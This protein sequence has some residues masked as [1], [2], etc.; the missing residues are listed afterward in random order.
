MLRDLFLGVMSSV[1]V[2]QCGLRAAGIGPER[3]D[4]IPVPPRA[5][6]CRARAGQ[7]LPEVSCGTTPCSAGVMCEWQPQRDAGI[8]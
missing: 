1:G 8:T 3:P 2:C 4:A 7:S 6:V 5:G